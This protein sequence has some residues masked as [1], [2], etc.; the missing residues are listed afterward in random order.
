[1]QRKPTESVLDL[2]ACIWQAAATCDFTPIKHPLYGAPS[3]R[4]TCSI[5]NKAVFL[6]AL[7]KVKDDE[8]TFFRAVQIAVEMEDAANVAKETTIYDS[9]PTQSVH[10]ISA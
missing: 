9:K 4:F 7:F 3:A 6:K 2:A 10:K 8:L 1:M 5:K